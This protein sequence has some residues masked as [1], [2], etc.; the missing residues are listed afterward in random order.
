MLPGLVFEQPMLFCEDMAKIACLMPSCQ[1]KKNECHL[2]LFCSPC[3]ELSSV[4]IS[5][6]L[7]SILGGALNIKQIYL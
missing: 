3:S 7:N 1:Y 4:V 2:C 5:W 6:F